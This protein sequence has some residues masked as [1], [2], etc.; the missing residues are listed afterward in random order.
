MREQITV[1]QR[2]LARHALGLPNKG[3][4]SYRNRFTCGIGTTDFDTW[5]AMADL[6]AATAW[7]FDMIERR[8]HG[9][10]ITFSLTR[11]GAEA[12]LDQGEMLDPEDFR[13]GR[14]DTPSAPQMEGV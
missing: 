5:S 6:G 2:E 14:S 13:G 9:G 12:V 3:R 4:R 7:P 8:Q 10:L 1:H 11:A